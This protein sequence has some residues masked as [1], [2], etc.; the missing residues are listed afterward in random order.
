MKKRDLKKLALL[1]IIGGFSMV[2]EP[3]EAGLTEADGQYLAFGGC[4]RGK[5]SNVADNYSPSSS[6]GCASSSQGCASSSQ[7][8]NGTQPG[9]ASECGGKQGCGG[10]TVAD[11]YRPSTSHS[12]GSSSDSSGSQGYNSY[13]PQQTSYR[14]Y[15]SCS[16]TPVQHSCGGQGGS[17]GAA[18]R[19]T[20]TN[21][22]YYQPQQTSQQS[23][24]NNNSRYYTAD[25]SA[26]TTTKSEEQ[27]QLL[28]KEE[29]KSKL[30]DQGKAM[31]D[32]LSP[33]GQALAIKLASQSCKG[34]NE[35]K[36]QNSCKSSENACAGQG[37]C[38]GKSNCS[39]K[40]KD[41]AVKVAALKM[42]EKRASLNS[43][44][45]K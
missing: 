13:R 1:G 10:G 33:E 31:F 41:K 37:G 2:S 9:Y 8:C 15:S 3:V 4:G 36:G 30:T 38:Q 26:P 44:A 39:F 23:A 11:N 35:C 17:C 27:G 14:T 5:C 25:A 32:R 40:D 22:Y 34:H 20:P 21:N 19:S 12:C 29:L 24:S 43:G 28:T 7:G 6:N 18:S 16:S 45:G 42:A